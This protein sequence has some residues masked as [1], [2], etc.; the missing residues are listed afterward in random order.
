MEQTEKD[1]NALRFKSHSARFS[2]RNALAR[3]TLYLYDVL[4]YKYASLVCSLSVVCLKQKSLM[5]L[6]DDVWI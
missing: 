6:W 3:F 4:R 5:A 2:F 1:L